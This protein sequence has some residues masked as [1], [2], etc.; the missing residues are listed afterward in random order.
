[1]LYIDK[2]RKDH[3]M[4]KDST[5]III[6][7]EILFL[8]AIAKYLPSLVSVLPNSWESQVAGEPRETKKCFH[9]EVDQKS[10]RNKR[11]RKAQADRVLH[12][13]KVMDHL[14][15]VFLCNLIPTDERKAAYLLS[16]V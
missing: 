11:L 5:E 2:H 3:L 10:S 4:I 7:F 15:T 9:D 12:V 13:E 6:N 1:M 14:E 8:A 16:Q